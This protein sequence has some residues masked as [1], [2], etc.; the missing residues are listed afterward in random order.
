MKMKLAA[1]LLA[2]ALFIPT[3]TLNMPRAY[4]QAAVDL[5]TL[6][7][8]LAAVFADKRT[9]AELSPEEL[10]TRFKLLRKAATAPDIP[11]ALHDQIVALAQAT[12]TD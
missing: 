5:A 1:S 3:M 10:K 8:D 4:A 12:K 11:P 7:P 2:A 9:L 6:P